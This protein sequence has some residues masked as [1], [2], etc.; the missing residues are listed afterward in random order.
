MAYVFGNLGTLNGGPW[1]A[2]DHVSAAMG[3]AWAA[4]ARHGDPNVAGRPSWQAYDSA[5]D[6]YMEFGDRIAPGAQWRRA[7][8]D[9]VDDYL[10]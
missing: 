2:D 10:R 6:N 7:Q 8:L 9:F 4:F 1:A 3:D 5:V